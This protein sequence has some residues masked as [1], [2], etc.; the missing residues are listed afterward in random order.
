MIEGIDFYQSRDYERTLKAL[1]RAIQE[2]SYF[3][4]AYLLQGDTYFDL[5]QIE[6]GIFSYQKA[7]SI[8]PEFSPGL[9]YTLATMQ[10][11]IGRY[12]DARLNFLRFLDYKGIPE[13]KRDKAL[14]ALKACDFGILAVA[15][16]VPFVP[17]N[18]GDSINT[19]FDEYINAV[20]ADGQ[21][22]YFTRADA[23]DAQTIDQD[24]QFEEDFYCAKLKDSSWC[25]ARNLGPPINTNG[26]EGAITI[27]P[28]GQMIFFAAC[29]RDDSYGSCDI[30]MSK[31]VGGQWTEPTNL[32]PIVNSGSWDSQPSF[33]SDGK[34]LYFASKRAGGKGSS[35]IWKT[36]LKTDGYWTQPI[37]LG[38]SINTKDAEMAPFIHPDD[39]TL[40]F[41]S[42][43]HVGMGGYDLFYVRKDVQGS[44]KRPV[45]LGYPINTFADEI[46]LVVNAA[47]NVAY[48]SSGKL[49]GTGGQDIYDFPL[50]EEAR[51]QKVTYMKGIVYDR[52]TNKRLG[53]QFDLTDLQSGKRVVMATSDPVTGEFLVAL[54]TNR[55]YALEVSKAGYLFYS[56]HFELT[57]E[58]TKAKPFIK[59]IP[60]QVIRQG[61]SVVL[62]N[63]F[64][65]TD[66]FDLKPESQIELN[67]LV[68]LLKANPAIKIE[69]GGHTDNEGK[70]D[71]NLLL[72][73][74]RAKA[75]YD[76]LIQNGITATRLTYSG[77][78]MTKPID[79]NTTPEGRAN[80]RR[81][82]FKVTSY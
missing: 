3:T 24:N 78:G 68:A 62:K 41:C 31:R 10:L 5:H 57:G 23:K 14:Y 51:P 67:R 21:V 35:D 71:H 72:S 28:D 55:N 50:Y 40:Y 33:S 25:L 30:Y 75:V 59:D 44:W 2:D 34:T 17:K 54:P 52:E 1:D 46:T 22:L 8:T 9:Y 20:T 26:N 36:E 39:Q 18:L 4:E 32:G 70:A 73:Q 11:S 49:G 76:Y 6:K 48:I 7:L 43:G 81:T 82:E 19:K 42:K 69:I 45:N 77:Y 74:N 38:D 16:P 79:S 65:D 27:S 53:A 58:A 29:N 13:Q 47:G 80:N 37:N 15:N 66:K 61:E 60:L 63:I 64:F 56:D 12:G